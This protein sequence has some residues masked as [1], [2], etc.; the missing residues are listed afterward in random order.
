MEAQR[1][2]RYSSYS[3]TTSA[4]DDVSGQGHASAAL[5]PLGKDPRFPLCRR[6]SGPQSRSGHRSQRNNPLTSA[7]DRTSIVRLSSPWPDIV[8]PELPRL[9]YINFKK[10][11]TLNYKP[12]ANK[13][14]SYILRIICHYFLTVQFCFK[15]FVCV[16]EA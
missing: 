1:E 15:S 8:L 12:T 6:L 2:R 7:G 3:F 10:K 5:C 13:S 4:L 14:S 16:G 11:A 9:I